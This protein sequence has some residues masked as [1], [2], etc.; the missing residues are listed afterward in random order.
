MGVM[1][2]E[3]KAS[4]ALNRSTSR[5]SVSGERPLS[6]T[7]TPI[8]DRNAPESP[9]TKR[10]RRSRRLSQMDFAEMD[11]EVLEVM[12]SDGG[13]ESHGSSDDDA[14]GDDDD[15]ADADSAMDADADAGSAS[16][17]S[18]ER[19]R[20]RDTADED[21]EDGASRSSAGR[22][23]RA[24]R[25]EHEGGSSRRGES[26]DLDASSAPPL[27]SDRDSGDDVVGDAADDADGADDADEFDSSTASSSDDD[28]D[29]DDDA[30][31]GL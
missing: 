19:K 6:A 8:A 16:S 4:V 9:N 18:A 28:D 27:S 7:V 25:S 22:D 5:R 14:A 31:G 13:S 10:R 11:R 20:K 12:G 29:D 23:L 15:D 17:S 24:H 30:D 21:G 26:G 2:P 3:R 1:I